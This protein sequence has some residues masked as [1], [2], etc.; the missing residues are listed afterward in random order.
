MSL[1]IGIGRNLIGIGGG[2]VPLPDPDALFDTRS[3]LSITD[4]IGGETV[5][6]KDFPIFRNTPSPTLLGTGISTFV[7]PGALGDLTVINF[8]K[9]DQGTTDYTDIK[10]F[11]SV[12]NNYV[13]ILHATKRVQFLYN[14]SF[15][16]YVTFPDNGNYTSNIYM[17]VWIFNS[18]TGVLVGRIYNTSTNY[19]SATKTGLTATSGVAPF[20][21]GMTAAGAT[22]HFLMSLHYTRILSDAEIT[23]IWDGTYASS[24]LVGLISFTSLE[25]LKSYHYFSVGDSVFEFHDAGGVQ[26][27]SPYYGT[28]I[29]N[30]QAAYPLIHGYTNRATQ[31]IAYNV[32]DSKGV[33]A[34]LDDIEFPASGCLWNMCDA[35]MDCSGIADATIKAIFDKSNRTYWKTSIETTDHYVDAGGGYYGKWCSTE[36]LPDFID[37]HAQSGHNGHIITSLRTTGTTVTGITDI[38]VYKTS[39]T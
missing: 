23:S 26:C 6:L 30:I 2:S 19:V 13:R 14:S 21:I 18:V 31:Q 24:G 22:C 35:R 20:R 36:L 33:T 11:A 39:L 38:R 37:L 10:G 7:V 12:T 25:Q 17:L 5:S 27:V 4:S 29:T 16:P 1:K 32:S 8:I 3:G 9:P 34:G 28:R 15:T